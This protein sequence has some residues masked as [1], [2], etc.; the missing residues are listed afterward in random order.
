MI[1]VLPV[2]LVATVLLREPGEPLS[3]ARAEGGAWRADGASSRRAGAH[4]YMPRPDRD[5]AFDVGLRML[6]LRH[7]VEDRDGLFAAR[8]EVTALL[9]YYANSIAHLRR[10][11]L[12]PA[13]RR[14]VSNAVMSRSSPGAVRRLQTFFR[15]YTHGLNQRDIRR[16]FECDAAR[17]FNVLTREHL[18]EL[19]RRGVLKRFRFRAKLAFLGLS[20]KLTPPRR[21]LFAASLLA[22]LDRDVQRFRVLLPPKGVRIYIQFSRFWG[23]GDPPPRPGVGGPR[24]RPRRAGGRPRAPG[25][26]PAAGLFAHSYR[27]PTSLAVR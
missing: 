17:A 27:T 4:V 25:R 6:T 22:V 21:L 26:P 19:V 10:G 8:P 13:P 14:C 1:P 23:H 3:R 24:A 20:Y 18:Q 9:R 12:K 5:Y 2:S 15:E 7:L 11:R 16:L